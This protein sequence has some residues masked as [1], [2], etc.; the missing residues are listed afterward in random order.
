MDAKMKG[1]LAF[2]KNSDQCFLWRAVRF[3]AVQFLHQNMVLFPAVSFVSNEVF[4]AL[5]VHLQ[6]RIGL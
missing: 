5:S 3:E 4:K 1:V 6:G 2:G